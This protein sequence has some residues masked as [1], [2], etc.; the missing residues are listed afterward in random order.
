LK[1]P[2]LW[3]SLGVAALLVLSFLPGTYSQ[4]ARNPVNGS[5]ILHI[6]P[7]ETPMDSGKVKM[8]IY[9]CLKDG[10]VQKTVKKISTM[11]CDTLLQNLNQLAQSNLSLKDKFEEKLSL[12]KQYEVVPPSISL[13]DIFDPQNIE[14]MS[15]DFDVVMGENFK[16]EFAPIFVIGGGFGLGI[17]IQ[18]RLF[19]GFTHFLALVGGLGAVICL[20][21]IEGTIYTLISYLLPVLVGYLAGYMGFIIFAVYPGVLYSNLV[22]LGFTPLT[23]W[24]QFPPV[25]E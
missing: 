22:M 2:T 23:V 13:R 21:P 7:K 6:A 24:V 4:I 11:D 1:N 15:T 8:K 18:E 25:E 3:F 19:N 9:T 12:L 10:S 14:D 16:A 5:T 20:D 17:G